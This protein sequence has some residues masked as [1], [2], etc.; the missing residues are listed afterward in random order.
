MVQVYAYCTK[1]VN[2]MY[3]GSEMLLIRSYLRLPDT[4]A[5]TKNEV[6]SSIGF[7]SI[8]L[9]IQTKFTTFY[10]PQSTA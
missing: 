9:R 6:R 7:A 2:C 3:P 5:I 1:T 4:V 10:V 8:L